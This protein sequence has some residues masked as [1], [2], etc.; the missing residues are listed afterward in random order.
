MCGNFGL[1]SLG[2]SAA[3]P[4]TSSHHEK[5]F[6]KV[7]LSPD[8]SL[9]DSM[10]EVAKTQGMRYQDQAAEDS[11]KQELINPLKILEAQTACTEIRGGQAGGFSTIE[12]KFA[13]KEHESRYEAMFNAS[14][15][16]VPELTRVRM[17]A[18]KRHP[19][20]ADLA[21][22]YLRHR[23]GKAL[24]PKSAITGMLP[25]TSILLM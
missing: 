24:D 15:V 20:A 10:H 17:V 18:R 22:L 5:S 2:A 7:P 11:A 9:H 25:L 12:Y 14:I 6:H 23:A 1:L 3:L 19:L 21:A 4:D 13:R 16:A 8:K